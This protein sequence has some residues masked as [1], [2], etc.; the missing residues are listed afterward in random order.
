MNIPT[1]NADNIIATILLIFLFFIVHGIIHEAT[2]ATQPI[3]MQS[4]NAVIYLKNKEEHCCSSSL[5]F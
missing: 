3:A 5:Y 4:E 1:A 2:N